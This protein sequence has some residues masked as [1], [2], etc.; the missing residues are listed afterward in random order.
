MGHREKKWV[1][2]QLQLQVAISNIGGWKE[3]S[4]PSE[5]SLRDVFVATL[6]CKSEEESL[7]EGLLHNPHK[8]ATALKYHCWKWLK[9]TNYLLTK[10]HTGIPV[11]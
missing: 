2:L 6:S 3:A 1:L 10:D 9:L 11:G 8:K 4:V 5:T 7:V